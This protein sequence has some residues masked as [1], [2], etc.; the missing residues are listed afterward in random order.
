MYVHITIPQT[1]AVSAL[2]YILLDLFILAY[3]PFSKILHEID[4]LVMYS[5]VFIYAKIH[6]YVYIYTYIY[7]SENMG[8]DIGRKTTS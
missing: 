4:N 2:M 5:A 1:T 3:L 7:A 6:I 8:G